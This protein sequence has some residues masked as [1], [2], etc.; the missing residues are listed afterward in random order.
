VIPK[1]TVVDTTRKMVFYGFDAG[2]HS[3][4]EEYHRLDAKT[5]CGGN[6]CS[7]GLGLEGEKCERT[8]LNFD[9]KPSLARVLLVASHYSKAVL[10]MYK[11]L[12]PQLRQFI[13]VVIR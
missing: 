10:Q 5:G 4:K 8:A 1:G 3:F 12:Q 6:Y 7:C 13:T 11:S 9:L 2:F